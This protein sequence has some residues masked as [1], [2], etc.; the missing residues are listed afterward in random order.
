[1]APSLT[2]Q[3]ILSV[4][5]AEQSSNVCGDF[6]AFSHVGLLDV[7]YAYVV[8]G[9]IIYTYVIIS[10]HFREG[11]GGPGISLSREEN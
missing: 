3:R 8:I 6:T 9:I 1:M 5:S 2:A 10:L 4:V 7:C 11:K